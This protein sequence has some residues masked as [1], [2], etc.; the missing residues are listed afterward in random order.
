MLGPIKLAASRA[1]KSRDTAARRFGRGFKHG[2]IKSFT[3]QGLGHMKKNP[4]KSRAERI[5]RAAGVTGAM[6]TGGVIGY[7]AG[8]YYSRRPLYLKKRKRR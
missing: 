2:Y 1:T 8:K 7:A 3:W 5:G 4:A 6:A